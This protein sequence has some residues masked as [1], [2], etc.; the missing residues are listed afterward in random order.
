MRLIHAFAKCDNGEATPAA[1]TSSAETR[2]ETTF[3]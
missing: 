2:V 3:A 1:D